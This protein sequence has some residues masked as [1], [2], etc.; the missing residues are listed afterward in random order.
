MYKLD[1]AKIIKVG[2]TG[3]DNIKPPHN[4][5]EPFHNNIVL[6]HNFISENV[7]SEISISPKFGMETLII[8]SSTDIN[9][10]C[11]NFNIIFYVT[12]FEK[13]IDDQFIDTIKNITKN[14]NDI[15]NHV[16]IIISD[17]D[18]LVLDDDD[19]LVFSD[20]AKEKIFQK[21]TK[22]IST[23]VN[24]NLFHISKL[25]I[26]Q[27]KIWNTISNE[28]TITNLSENQIDILASIILK[29]SKTLSLVDKKREIRA[30]LKNIDVAT[31]LDETGFNDL[32]EKM[33]TY[34]K[35]VKQKQ[36]VKS[37][38]EHYC[39]KLEINMEKQNMENLIN[40]VKEIYS[41]NYFKTDI[42]E[43]FITN[44]NNTLASKLKEFYNKNKNTIVSTLNNIN[45]DITNAYKYHSFLLEINQLA[46][47]Y[48]MTNII[49]A[50]STEIKNMDN[51]I[52]NHHHKE[53]EKITDLEKILAFVE[54]FA[55]KDKNNLIGFFDKIKSNI[56]IIHDNIDKMDKWVLFI[57]K[58]IKMKIPGETLIHLIED[59]IMAKISYY[60]DSTRINSKEIT[61]IYPQCLHVFLLP[62][63]DKNF[64]FK[65]LYMF[66][67]Y[68]IRYSG[69]NVAEH[70]KKIK[71]EEYYK[72]LLLEYKLLELAS[73]STDENSLQMNVSEMNI[74]ESFGENL[75]YG[76]QGKK[77][78]QNINIEQKNNNN[79]TKLEPNNNVT[80]LELNNDVTK[81]EPNNVQKSENMNNNESSNN[82]PISESKKKINTS[83][84]IK[85]KQIDKNDDNNCNESD[86]SDENDNNKKFDN[87]NDKKEFNKS[88]ESKESKEF[89]NS[90][91]DVSDNNGDNGKKNN[92]KIINNKKINNKNAKKEINESYKS[93]DGT[94]DD[95]DDHNDK[96][97][98]KKIIHNKKI[99]NKNT[100]KE[101]SEPNEP[102]NSDGSASDDNNDK[103]N[104]TK[105]TI[106]KQIDKKIPAKNPITTKNK[107]S[108]KDS[109]ST[110]EESKSD[111]S[112]E[113]KSNKN[114]K[115]INAINKKNNNNK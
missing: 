45:N 59:I 9:H 90:D 63:V 1:A 30:A 78:A 13:F 43:K 39:S 72:M 64:I 61:V 84:S 87:K 71:S 114:T 76:G 73:Y 105:K 104:S 111:N 66:V 96:K 65:R 115:K 58:C 112:T 16:F 4:I 77:S 93:D 12:N 41:I 21:I 81:F 107:A 51:I 100:K 25:S 89:S 7:L 54:I 108:I 33:T 10:E 83:K 20:D 44:I 110:E 28:N 48:N 69:R 29:K 52:I 6:F 79:V 86:N 40:L 103:K 80:K 18:D 42:Y 38:Y 8:E 74:L 70:I 19:D 49:S 68:H 14:L 106:S 46:K 82:K 94:S 101:V 26:N 53:I 50:T 15:R 75:E 85:D 35:I 67:S 24:K 27:A 37:N 97:I 95:N 2:I 55:S 23:S 11:C 109:D 3:S 56:K 62:L 32:F 113:T 22:L 36:Y 31:K 102:D 17:C 47:N 34:M 5:T 92:K 88:N 99:N 57:D 98:N 91:D 60:G